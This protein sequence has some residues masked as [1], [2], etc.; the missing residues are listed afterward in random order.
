MKQP[1]L[2]LIFNRPD[3]TRRIFEAISSYRPTQLFV[4]A[5]GPRRDRAGEEKLC[6]DARAVI[7]SVN[8]PSK[9]EKKF[10][11]ANL[12][13]RRAV[14]SALDWFFSNNASGIVIEDDCLPH[15]SFFSYCEYML[16]KYRDVREVFH[17]SGNCFVS[18]IRILVTSFRPCRTFG[19]GGAGEE[20]GSTTM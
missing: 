9:V 17:V 18:R 20:R 6:E 15:P 5:D 19:V 16:E 13:C 8:W 11:K 14:S 2:M 1:V 12:G 7:E 4:A 10:E 3:T